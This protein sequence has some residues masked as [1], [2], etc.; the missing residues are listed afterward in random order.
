MINKRFFTK[1]FALGLAMAGLTLVSCSKNQLDAGGG[2]TKDGGKPA[3]P[4]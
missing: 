4:C 3:A 1:V 2:N